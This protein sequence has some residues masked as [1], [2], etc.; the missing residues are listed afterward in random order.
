MADAEA[1]P[2]LMSADQGKGPWFGHPSQLARLFST[3]AME[4]F[5]F[6]GMRALLVLYLVGHFQYKDVASNSLYGGVLSLVYLTPVIGGMLADRVLGYKRAVKFGAL[7]MS[8]GYLIL[9]FGGD[10]AKP[11]AT[12]QGQHYDVLEQGHGKATQRYIIDRGEKLVIK[13][14]DD[15]SVSLLGADGKEV[16]HIAGTDFV[17]DATRDPFFAA[18]ALVALALISVGNGFFKP[19]ISTIV[20]AL[21]A[22]GDRRRDAGYAIFYMGIN[23]GALVSQMICPLLALGMGDW[24]G[25]GWSAGFGLAAAGMLVA[26]ALIQFSGEQLRGYGDPPS[27][28]GADKAWLVYL[29]TAL[30]VPVV[31]FLLN[32]VLGQQSDESN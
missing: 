30:S 32:N 12:I 1:D 26:W 14:N 20:G 11:Y 7:V 23:V 17:P 25:I 9:C 6:Y 15:K 13:G 10:P 21:Y 5:G 19:N 24:P 29:G 28:D 3:E 4:R 18:L 27:Q 22:D 8:L 16:R 2:A 31:W